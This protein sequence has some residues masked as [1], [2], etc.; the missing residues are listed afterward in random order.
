MIRWAG[1][2][3]YDK[4][5]QYVLHSGKTDATFGSQN[6]INQQSHMKVDTFPTKLL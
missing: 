2:S 4:K 5:P 6:R 1:T 3:L